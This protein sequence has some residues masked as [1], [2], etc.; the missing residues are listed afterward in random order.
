MGHQI[1]FWNA[2]TEYLYKKNISKKKSELANFKKWLMFSDSDCLAY[3]F[4]KKNC[5]NFYTA[6][7]KYF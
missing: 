6:K 4:N 1:I 3:F 2:Y 5:C 7:Q